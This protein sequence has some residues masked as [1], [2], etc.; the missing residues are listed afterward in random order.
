MSADP[1]SLHPMTLSQRARVTRIK[2][3]LWLSE[4]R[5]WVFWALVALM[6][7]AWL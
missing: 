5:W 6:F 1:Y 3:R 4:H 7:G 2:A